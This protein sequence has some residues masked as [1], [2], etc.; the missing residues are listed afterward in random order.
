[1]R[2]LFS[3]A[4]RRVGL[5]KCFK[6]A[7][8]ELNL[9]LETYA[10]DMVP[11]WS[12][13]C[14]IVDRYW[15]VPRCT[16]ESFVP[17]IK[18]ICSTHDIDLIVPTIDTE[19]PIYSSIR[20]DLQ[21]AGTQV[22]LPPSRLV[23]MAYD[24]FETATL[25]A[26]HGI[27]TPRS[28]LSKD[29]PD[30]STVKLPVF[31][32]PLRGSRSVGAQIIRSKAALNAVKDEGNY[33]I[34]EE[35]YGDEY[36]VNCYFDSDAG[37]ICTVPHYRKLTRGGEVCLAETVHVKAFDYVAEKLLEI[38]PDLN[39]VISIQGFLQDGTLRI[40]EINARLSG[41]YPLCDKAGGT[42]ARWILQKLAGQKPDYNKNWREGVR[43]LRYHEAIYTP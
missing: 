41:G 16:D 22:L 23:A 13:A 32:K 36:T 37:F 39:G 34:Q 19:L 33:I 6:K 21:K 14:K 30:T 24:K 28:R 4:G 9:D 43:M 35:C 25:L 26:K 5:I 11:E 31:A 12:P 29:L 8:E 27:N 15:A 2:L 18:E 7:A 40:F 17:W 42:Y 3:S 38:F 1:M 10:V 20:E